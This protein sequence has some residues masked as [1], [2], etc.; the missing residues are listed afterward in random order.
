MRSS[1]EASTPAISMARCEDTTA[2]C[3]RVSPSARILRSLQMELCQHFTHGRAHCQACLW[4][5]A[6]RET[7]VGGSR[8]LT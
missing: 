7:Q 5:R 3:D 4:A 8:A 2:C 1:C 6:A